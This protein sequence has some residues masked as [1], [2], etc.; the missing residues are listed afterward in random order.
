M[1]QLLSY[2]CEKWSDDCH[3]VNGVDA[4]ASHVGSSQ[5][6]RGGSI[7]DSPWIHKSTAGSGPSH[8]HEFKT[9]LESNSK[10]KGGTSIYYFTG[11][12]LTNWRFTIVFYV[13]SSGKIVT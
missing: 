3:A 11:S 2:T 7:R 8:R 13:L 6:A 9:L 4:Q 5:E 1:T 10:N 12:Y